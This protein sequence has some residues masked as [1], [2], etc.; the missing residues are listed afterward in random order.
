MNRRDR[1][2]QKKNKERQERLRRE[3]RVG[4]S[5][6]HREDVDGS[7]EEEPN[8]AESLP[9]SA[10]ATESSIA[11]ASPSHTREDAGG[12]RLFDGPLDNFFKG[13]PARQ[14]LDALLAGTDTFSIVKT[15]EPAEY[16]PGHLLLKASVCCEILV[17][18]ELVAAGR[19][20]PSRHLPAPVAV[21]LLER[22]VF[23]SPGV[24]AMAAAAVRRVGEFSEL[25]QLWDTVRLAP[26]WLHGVEA[27]IGRLQR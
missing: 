5:P 11:E 18:A 16:V 9:D 26:E 13:E 6:S 17:A 1:R 25:R 14:W 3:K 22:D 21:W 4:P 2:K 7:A 27:L 8:D 15:L 12:G 20:R 19:G 10:L 24:V 23:F